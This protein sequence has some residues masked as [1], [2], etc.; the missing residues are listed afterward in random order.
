MVFGLN[1]HRCIKSPVIACFRWR[2]S[3][4]N[5][6]PTGVEEII[7]FTDSPPTHSIETFTKCLKWH[8]NPPE[9]KKCSII[10]SAIWRNKPW[11]L[12]VL[13]AKSWNFTVD[14]ILTLTARRPRMTLLRKR[15]PVPTT[16][17]PVYRIFP[18]RIIRVPCPVKCHAVD[19]YINFFRKLCLYYYIFIQYI[20]KALTF[21]ASLVIVVVVQWLAALTI[22]LIFLI[23]NL[24]TF[25]KG[26]RNQ[27]R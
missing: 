17:Q 13:A 9:H 6:V 24:D 16:D 10:I 1:K 23:A 25:L 2:E 7:I 21:S 4:V 8:T 12:F 14:A 18:P 11:K 15:R 19:I 20:S 3:N 26:A 27:R 5:S 22:P